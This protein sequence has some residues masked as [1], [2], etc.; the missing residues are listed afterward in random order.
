MS[1]VTKGLYD[2]LINDVNSHWMIYAG[3]LVFLMQAGFSLLEAGSVGAKNATNILFKNLLVS[4]IVT[5]PELS[6]YQ[7]NLIAML[8][9]TRNLLDRTPTL[10]MPA[11]ALPVFMPWATPSPMAKYLETQLD[12]IS[13]SGIRTSSSDRRMERSIGHSFFSGRLLP[14][15]RPLSVVQL[16][17]ASRSKHTSFTPFSSLLLFTR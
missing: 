12:Q 8:R 2:D 3:T 5:R 1:N 14:R 11:S 15:L 17:N 9:H 7:Q 16:R 6:T 4:S 13:S 10:R